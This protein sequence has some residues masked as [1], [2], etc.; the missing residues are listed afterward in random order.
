M[1]TNARSGRYGTS[2]NQRSATC[3]ENLSYGSSLSVQGIQS[4]CA[5]FS[6]IAEDSADARAQAR[7]QARG[8]HILEEKTKKDDKGEEELE[9]KKPTRTRLRDVSLDS[10]Y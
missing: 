2:L 8:E 7:G 3:L 5:L 9:E 6:T 10:C 1:R 4:Q